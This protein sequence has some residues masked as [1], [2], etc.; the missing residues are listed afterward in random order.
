M[1]G[2]AIA[3][4]YGFSRLRRWGR[5][6]ALFSN[7]LLV[8]VVGIPALLYRLI[9]TPYEW[10]FHPMDTLLLAL[11]SIALPGLVLAFCFVPSVRRVMIR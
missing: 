6:L 1:T 3:M 5:K 4:M 9:I 11:F 8:V 2:Y 7:G 10:F